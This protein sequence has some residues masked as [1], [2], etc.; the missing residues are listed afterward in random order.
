MAEGISIRLRFM[1]LLYAAIIGNALQQLHPEA[2]DVRLFF[3]LFLILVIL[4]DFFLYHVDVAPNNSGVEGARFIGLV[5]EV[6]ILILWLFSFM[7]FANS[8]NNR[9]FLLYIAGFF[10][11][12]TVAGLVNCLNERIF[13]SLSFV[14]ELLFVVCPVI[15]FCMWLGLPATGR[16]PSH[17]LLVIVILWL[18][19]AVT[20]WG[21]TFHI[22]RRAKDPSPAEDRG[23]EGAGGFRFL[24]PFRFV[25]HK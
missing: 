5:F 1:D 2:M 22:K 9:V 12:K 11:L 19:Q 10:T 25:S 24:F 7:A 6:S 21:L 18:S 16:V 17:V 13:F 15:I 4:E 3:G 20:W 8:A 23:S 14:R